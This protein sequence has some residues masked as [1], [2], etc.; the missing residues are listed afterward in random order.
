MHF[1]VF[2]RPNADGILI[3]FALAEKR[4]SAGHE[5]STRPKGTS[6][7]IPCRHLGVLVIRDTHSDC[8]AA[9]RINSAERARARGRPAL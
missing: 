5:T 2:R 3:A 7:D 8:R 6:C 9:E 4:R 1:R